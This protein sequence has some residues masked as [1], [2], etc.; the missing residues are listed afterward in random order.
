MLNTM[1]E[2]QNEASGYTSVSFLQL[3]VKSYNWNVLK[4]H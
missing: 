4:V 3:S 1:M 2:N